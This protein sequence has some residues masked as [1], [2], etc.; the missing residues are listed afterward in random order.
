ML[1]DYI[2]VP[3]DARDTDRPLRREWS[4]E[5]SPES[6]GPST[7][8]TFVGASERKLKIVALPDQFVLQ[9]VTLSL[10]TEKG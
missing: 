1:L 6:G 5:T 4:L 8:F 9:T 10:G 3:N 7:M 2:D